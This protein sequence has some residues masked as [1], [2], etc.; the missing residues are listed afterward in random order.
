MSQLEKKYQ[1]I[2]V[3]GWVGMLFLLLTMFITDIIELAMRGD[4][5]ETSN[6]LSKDP[7]AA[8]LWFLSFL[9][10]ANVLAQMSIRAISANKC[11]WWVFGITIGYGL[12]FFLHQAVHL[13]NGEGF[14]IHFVIDITHN[15]LAIWASWAAYKWSKMYQNE[16]NLMPSK[17]V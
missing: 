14:D 1:G 16:I 8:G 15:I 10:C 3:Q 13:L 4:Y 9:I 17:Y 5:T 12:F 6:F 7:G 2:V 11:R